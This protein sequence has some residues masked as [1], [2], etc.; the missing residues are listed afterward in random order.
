MNTLSPRQ[1]PN[2]LAVLGLSLWAS[3][4][5][6]AEPRT[7]ALDAQLGPDGSW[8]GTV[9]TAE[10]IPVPGTRLELTRGGGRHPALSTVTDERGCFRFKNV[11]AGP[12][13]LRCGDEIRVCRLWQCGTA[14]P[15]AGKATL[16]VVGGPIIRGKLYDWAA[17]H[18]VLTYT[19]IAAAIVVPVAVI[20]SAQSDSPASP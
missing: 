15:A 2:L 16:I 6:W 7:T 12:Y 13:G 20:G 10:G 5:A 4:V 8:A 1:L 11:H 17:E 18:P 3:S 14:P 9:V 19:G